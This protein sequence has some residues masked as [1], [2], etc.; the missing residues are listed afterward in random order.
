LKNARSNVNHFRISGEEKN[1]F[2]LLD[3]AI[4]LRDKSSG[5][6]DMESIQ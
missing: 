2:E 4:E 5:C 3:E 6:L 1:N